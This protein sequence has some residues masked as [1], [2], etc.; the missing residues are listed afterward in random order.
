MTYQLDMDEE[1]H[2]LLR[3]LPPSRKKKLKESLKAI[4][5]NP[6]IGKPLQEDLRGFVSYR[7]GR[8]RIIYAVD[9]ERKRVQIVAIGPRRNIYEELEKDLKS[10]KK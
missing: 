9:R 3:H 4:A 7:V 2:F 6:Q 10:K 1:I 5:S 8:I